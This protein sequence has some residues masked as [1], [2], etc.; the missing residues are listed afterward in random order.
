MW[1]SLSQRNFLFTMATMKAMTAWTLKDCCNCQ[2]GFLG[3]SLAVRRD[4]SPIMRPSKKS[5]YL[6]RS[7]ASENGKAAMSSRDQVV[8]ED[9]G[10]GDAQR[11]QDDIQHLRMKKELENKTQGSRKGRNGAATGATTENS[12]QLKDVVETL[13]VADFF[14]ILAI[15]AWFLAGVAQQQLSPTADSALL[16]AWFPLW[17]PVFQPALGIFMAGAL[18]SGFMA[19]QRN[20]A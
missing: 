3:E 13:L 20:R 19:W 2:F 14:F 5:A 11:M 7:Q 17:D 18:V 15:L 6:L 1:S 12:S 8:G 9:F 4:C 10:A 16:G